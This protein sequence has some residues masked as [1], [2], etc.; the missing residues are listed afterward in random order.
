MLTVIS[1]IDLTV[2]MTIDSYFNYL[3]SFI[4]P[5]LLLTQFRNL[6]D[7]YIKFLYVVYEALPI[8][9]LIL[10]FIMY[11]AWM[12]KSAYTAT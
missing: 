9:F 4:R 7:V 3:S 1:L 8:F 10:L 5:F 6:R 12:M 2:A 11:F